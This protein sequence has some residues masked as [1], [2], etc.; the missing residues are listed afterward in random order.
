MRR[1]TNPI[2]K[3]ELNLDTSLIQECYITFKQNNIE[4]EKTVS[5]CSIEE[6]C[7]SVQLSQDETLS[8]VTKYPVL[9]QARIKLSDGTICATDIIKLHVDEIIKDGEI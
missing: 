7:V 5:D 2:V 4:I 8:F 3:M 1:G 9:T 6:G